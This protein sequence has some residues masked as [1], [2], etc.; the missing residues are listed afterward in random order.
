MNKI[1]LSIEQM[2]KLQKLGVEQLAS[3][4]QDA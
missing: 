3:E 2:W 1:A 4:C